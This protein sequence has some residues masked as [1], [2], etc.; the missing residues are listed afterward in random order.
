MNPAQLAPTSQQQLQWP[1]WGKHFETGQE[2]APDL[3]EV[4]RLL[5]LNTQ[6]RLATTDQQRT[7]AWQEMLAIRAEGV[8]TIGT[9]TRVLQPIVVN[10]RLRNL[11]DEGLWNWEPN[12]YLGVYRPDH[13]WLAPET[14][15]ASDTTQTRQSGEQ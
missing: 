1:K 9:V 3:P 6:W 11:P 15:V 7:A 4:K 5:T 2:T 8:F 14:P 10:N 13:F 12:G